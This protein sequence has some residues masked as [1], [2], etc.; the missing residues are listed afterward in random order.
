MGIGV[1]LLEPGCPCGLVFKQLDRQLGA[2]GLF[3]SHA[4]MLLLRISY[5]F[6]GSFFARPGR[7]KNLQFSILNSSCSIQ[8]SRR[9]RHCDSSDDPTNVSPAMMPSISHETSLGAR[10]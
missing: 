9:K 10:P 1:V 6:V 2:H 7:K 3:S 5:T 8:S 4:V